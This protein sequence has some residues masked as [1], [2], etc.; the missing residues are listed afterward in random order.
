V[1]VYARLDSARIVASRQ[2]G[3][4]EVGV[5]PNRERIVMKD[6]SFELCG[7]E[8]VCGWME[9]IAVVEEASMTRTGGDNS[10]VVA[11]SVLRHPFIQLE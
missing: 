7:D 10:C 9:F 11:T 4:S 8:G 6:W 5:E 2:W 1:N 3:G